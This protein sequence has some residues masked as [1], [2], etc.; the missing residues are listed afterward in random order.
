MLQVTV[1][2]KAIG[3]LEFQYSA[4]RLPADAATANLPAPPSPCPSNASTQDGALRALLA[5]VTPAALTIPSALRAALATPRALGWAPGEGDLS[6][7]LQ[8][9]AGKSDTA[10]TFIYMWIN[11]LMSQFM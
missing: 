8:G 11:T 7:L 5:A 2:L 3:G 4:V 9:R 6:E 1:A 10:N